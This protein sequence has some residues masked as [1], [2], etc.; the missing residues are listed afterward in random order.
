MV[1]YN[2][3]ML[4]HINNGI[5]TSKGGKTVK[6]EEANMETVV[7]DSEDVVA[8]STVTDLGEG[9]HGEDGNIDLGL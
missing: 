6:Y 5:E 4:V 2:C 9:D 7:F 3:K 8:T 1:I